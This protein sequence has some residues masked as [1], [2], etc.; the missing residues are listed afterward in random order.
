[1]AAPLGLTYWSKK[2]MC[3]ARVSIIGWLKSLILIAIKMDATLF[4]P[5]KLIVHR[6]FIMF[7]F[8]ATVGCSTSKE[9][10]STSCIAGIHRGKF[11]HHKFSLHDQL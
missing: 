10:A 4:V 2:M 6:K 8:G 9:I 7:K 11:G 5:S 3:K 1:M